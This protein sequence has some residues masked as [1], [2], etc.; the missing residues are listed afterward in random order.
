MFHSQQSQRGLVLIR[1]D[2]V[3]DLWV[4]DN[5]NLPPQAQ[6][7]PEEA[8]SCLH[9]KG[10]PARAVEQLPRRLTFLPFYRRYYF[11]IKFHD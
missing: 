11:L 3:L 7:G 6:L 9:L 2:L 8:R 10:P 5:C 4:A 1:S